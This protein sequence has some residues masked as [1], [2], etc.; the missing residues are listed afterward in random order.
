MDA[1]DAARRGLRG[2]GVWMIIVFPL[3]PLVYLLA[4]R[5]HRP[6]ILA[7]LETDDL[8]ELRAW[9]RAEMRAVWV[10][11]GL[12]CAVVLAVVVAAFV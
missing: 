3:S 11:L 5:P 7:A 4:V 8:P 2:S 1:L 9:Y 6:V 12:W 10:G